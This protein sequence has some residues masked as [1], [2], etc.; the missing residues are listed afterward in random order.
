MTTESNIIIPRHDGTVL[1]HIEV[2][3]TDN[4]YWSWAF[5]AHHSGASSP[6]IY[7]LRCRAIE[8]LKHNL[9]QVI[10]R[11]DGALPMLKALEHIGRGDK[12]KQLRLF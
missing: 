3:L 8:A 11:D 6:A 4:G 5:V 2:V 12:P 7:L 10:H 1:N 9:N